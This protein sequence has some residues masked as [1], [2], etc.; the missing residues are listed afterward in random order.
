MPRKKEIS[1]RYQRKERLLLDF[2]RRGRLG[3]LFVE[4]GRQLQLSEEVTVVVDF[5]AQKRNFRLQG[6][7]VARRR[8]SIEPPLAPGVQV[9]IPSDQN[10]TLQLI[11]DHAEGKQVEFTDRT[12]LRLPCSY[13]VSYRRDQDFVQEF[14][15]D[16]GVGGT[17]IRSRQLFPVNTEVECRLRPPGYL[18]GIKLRCRVAWLKETGEPRGMGVEFLFESERQRRKIQELVRKLAQDR[19]REIKRKMEKIR[20]KDRYR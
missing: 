5:P 19:G 20:R 15:E 16:I 13:V 4:T 6:R 3:V 18:M 7:V 11:L 9:E 2:T 14:A 12:S 1:A 8:A 17:F 10:K